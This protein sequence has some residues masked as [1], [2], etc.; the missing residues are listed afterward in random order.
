MARIKAVTV[1]LRL[2]FPMEAVVL[3]LVGVSGLGGKGVRVP[4]LRCC[5]PSVGTA[6]SSET[7]P[8]A[9]G[10]APA[11]AGGLSVGGDFCTHPECSEG[12]SGVAVLG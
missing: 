8:L 5:G 11:N 3:P 1:L 2:A 12:R 9:E 6:I 7:C 4:A 10:R